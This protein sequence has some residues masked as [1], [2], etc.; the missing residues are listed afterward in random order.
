MLKSK[1]PRTSGSEYRRACYRPY[2]QLSRLW[3][4]SFLLTKP[5]N[6][7]SSLLSDIPQ[8]LSTHNDRNWE[9]SGAHPWI[10][11]LVAFADSSSMG[12]LNCEWVSQ[13]MRLWRPLPGS[14]SNSSWI[15]TWIREMVTSIK[16]RWSSGLGT[17]LSPCWG[18][19]TSYGGHGPVACWLQDPGYQ[20][21]DTCQNASSSRGSTV[22]PPPPHTQ[23][24]KSL[25]SNYTLL[26]IFLLNI[27]LFSFEFVLTSV[28]SLMNNKIF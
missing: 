11:T 23:C 12:S 25:A 26:S 19:C 28:N 22:A 15:G 1:G 7:M 21:T 17:A 2:I 14:G 3:V 10:Q 9:E 16:K 6:S 27:P 24:N 4:H 18:Q 20:V 13:W 8:T 5:I